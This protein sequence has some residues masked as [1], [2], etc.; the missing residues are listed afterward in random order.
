MIQP[1]SQLITYRS[2]PKNL[3]ET[4]DMLPSKASLS[5]DTLLTTDV[6]KSIDQYLV[7]VFSDAQADL[8]LV[9]MSEPI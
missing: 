9:S 2:L 8:D 7:D 6:T 4:V 3:K 5:A 1:V